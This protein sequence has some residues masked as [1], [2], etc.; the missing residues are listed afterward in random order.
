MAQ[1]VSFWIVKKLDGHRVVSIDPNPWRLEEAKE[2]CKNGARHGQRYA[3]TR[4]DVT[5]DLI[6]KSPVK[7]IS[8]V[9]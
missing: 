7:S 8:L 9:A 2:Y 5:I 3:M 1:V 6:G 4:V